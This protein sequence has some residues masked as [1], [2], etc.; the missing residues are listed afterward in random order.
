MESAFFCL[1]T[2][3]YTE[4]SHEVYFLGNP[5]LLRCLASVLLEISAKEADVG[6]MIFPSHFLDVLSAT[7]ELYFQLQDY[8]LVYDGLGCVAC[9]LSHD[10]GKIL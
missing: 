1:K 10:V 4:T 7:L 2:Y 6:K 8:I 9:H 5:H 3:F